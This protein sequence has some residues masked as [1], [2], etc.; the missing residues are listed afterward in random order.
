[1]GISL[2]TASNSFHDEFAIEHYRYDHMF[3]IQYPSILSNL[4][5]LA[6]GYQPVQLLK[7]RLFSLL[8]KTPKEA[9]LTA[10]LNQQIKIY[11]IPDERV[12]S[13]SFGFITAF[14]DDHDEPLVIYTPLYAGDALL[15]DLTAALT[16]TSFDLYFFDEHDREMM[17]VH[18]H[19]QNVEHFRKV[20][21]VTRFPSFCQSEVAP[22]LKAMEDWFGRRTPDDDNRAFIIEFESPL[23]PDNLIIIDARP[24]AYDYRGSNGNV[25]VTSLERNEPGPFQERDIV[26]LFQRAFPGDSIFLNP[27]R[28]DTGTELADILIHNDEVIVLVQAKDS[29]NNKATI[30]RNI[31]RKRTVIRAHIEKGAR[32]LRGA[33]SYVTNHD[34]LHIKNSNGAYALAVNGRVICG[35][36]IVREMFDDDY[37]PSSAPVLNVARACKLPCVLMDYAALHVM[38]LHL[39]D[40]ALLLGAFF[41]LFEVALEKGEYPKPRFLGSPT[42]E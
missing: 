32:Q 3:S 6:Y 8:V 35:V 7:E 28:T 18:A 27:F 30:R 25:A 16:Q 12:V 29:P 34:V 37:G 15:T 23:Y 17:G 19:V 39:R 41:Q 36:V 1:M 24:E 13:G 31:D 4:S 42:S 11:L 21:D 26:S 5:Q 9:I 33:L 10:R 20:L 14:F 40:P 2:A 38:T 22:T